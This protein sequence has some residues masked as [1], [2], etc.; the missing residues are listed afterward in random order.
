MTV[1]MLRQT[2]P[3]VR[4]LSIMGFIGAGMMI[5][6][7]LIMGVAGAASGRPEMLL[8]CILYPLLGLLYIFPAL[9]LHR[10][11]S[12]IAEF[13][14]YGQSEHLDSALE[15]QKSFWRFSGIMT[16]VILCLYALAIVIFIFVSIMSVL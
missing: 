14:L 7:G 11:A 4:F 3:W 5:L 12:R 13:L 10:Y 6:G 8:L 1:E 15:A 16:L 2:K 9:F